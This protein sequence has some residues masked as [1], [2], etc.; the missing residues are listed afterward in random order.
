MP[1]DC[2]LYPAIETLPQIAQERAINGPR[3]SWAE[4][5]P[6]GLRT[7][8]Y[9]STRPPAGPAPPP[10]MHGPAVV[11]RGGRR[12]RAHRAVAAPL[13]GHAARDR[14]H[15][16]QRDPRLVRRDRV[17]WRSPRATPRAGRPRPA[18]APAP[19]RDRTPGRAPPNR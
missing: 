12:A 15:R 5:E 4:R 2:G 1:T 16:P 6:R 8:R 3:E 13:A 14:R 7:G 17:L 19:S 18:R 9:Y 11:P 10:D